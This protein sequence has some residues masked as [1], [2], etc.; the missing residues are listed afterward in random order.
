LHALELQ[1]SWAEKPDLGLPLARTEEALAIYQRLGDLGGMSEVASTLAQLWVRAG[2]TGRA[3]ELYE[4]AVAWALEG[5]DDARRLS[6]ISYFAGLLYD[7]GEVD[8]AIA[9]LEE[10]R[11][12]AR[13]TGDERDALRIARLL[14]FVL[15]DQGR[16]AEAHDLLHQLV[17][18]VMRVREPMLST[19]VVGV[20]VDLFVAL[21]DAERVSR[22]QA[23]YETLGY[24]IGW[25]SRFVLPA[26][27]DKQR[28]D[29]LRDALGAE[30]WERGRAEGASW[31]AQETLTYIAGTAP[32]R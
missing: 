31:S 28:Q 2:D 13:T 12:L 26:D 30:A 7:E 3:R 21:G 9:L 11:D 27:A 23:A 5:G 24:A 25:E 20:F 4:R 18:D 14:A 29:A 19:M 22:L 32:V 10:G 8:E 15:L 1:N 6:A 16:T 17:P